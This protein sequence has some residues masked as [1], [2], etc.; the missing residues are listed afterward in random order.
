[1]L[2]NIDI[3]THVYLCMFINISI[4][5]SDDYGRVYCLSLFFPVNNIFKYMYDFEL[6]FNKLK[7]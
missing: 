3:C 7:Q 5:L 4:V 2:L 6:T 1:M